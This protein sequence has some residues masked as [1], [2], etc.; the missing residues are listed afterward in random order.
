MNDKNVILNP[1]RPIILQSGVTKITER[2]IIITKTRERFYTDDLKLL[3]PNE[4][5]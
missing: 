3:F 2:Q 1:L 4:D 5:E